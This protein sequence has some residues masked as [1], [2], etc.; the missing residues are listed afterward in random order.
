MEASQRK[1]VLRNITYG[2]YVTTTAQGDAIAA[3]GVSW[4][5][6]CSFEPPLVMMALRKDGALCGLLRR[7]GRGVVH[8]L[9]EGQAALAKSFFG[10]TK[11]DVGTINGQPYRLE[12]GQPVLTA[13]PWY[14]HFE[15]REWVD[16]GD[17]AIAVAAVTGARATGGQTVPLALRDTSWSYSG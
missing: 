13:L 10:P 3:A 12:E 14:F 8:I 5:S 6:Q 4:L 7:S 2:L 1:N 11:H 17:H 16:R 15:V 9:G